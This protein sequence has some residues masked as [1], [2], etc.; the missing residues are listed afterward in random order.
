M[1]TLEHLQQPIVRIS[2]NELAGVELLARFKDKGPPPLVLGD[3]P[4]DWLMLDIGGLSRIR[5]SRQA[6]D[7]ESYMV[8]INLSRH[9]VAMP[10]AME[11]FLLSCQRTM[12][13]MKIEVVVEIDEDIQLE[14]GDLVRLSR[15]IHSYGMRVAMDDYRGNE[16]CVQ[17]SKL[18]CWDF[19]KV[20]T[21]KRPAEEFCSDIKMLS[22]IGL[23]VIA[24][25]IETK[26][27]YEAVQEAGALW[28]QGYYTGRPSTE[29]L[30]LGSKPTVVTSFPNPAHSDSCEE[31]KILTA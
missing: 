9:I 10:W 15:R 21:Q 2:S 17:R 23:P 19:V 12:E 31:P 22:S 27:T 5:Y 14:D 26:E 4:A 29:R 6:K 18:Y 25:A 11:L 8:F 7:G 13:K 30:L 16:I 24:E 1:L 20:C 28:V 3:N